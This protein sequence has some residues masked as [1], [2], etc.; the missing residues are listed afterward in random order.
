MQK[1]EYI[2]RI[3]YEAVEDLRKDNVENAEIRFAPLQHLNK[4][5]SP[6]EIVKAA[7]AGLLQGEKDFGGN[8]NLILCG[9]RQN[10]DSVDVAKLAIEAINYKVCL[11]Y[12]SPSPRDATLS[13]MPSSA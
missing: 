13:R 11:L 12:T 3:S 10:N 1:Y 9:M 5:T 2:E 6:I 8:F 7:C 4:E